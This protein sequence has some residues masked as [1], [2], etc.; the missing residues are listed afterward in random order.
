MKRSL[1]WV[2]LFLVRPLRLFDLGGHR[3][4]PDPRRGPA[5]RADHPGMT[6]TVKV[7]G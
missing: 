1:T 6:R 5:P 7:L 3:T 4:R 2:A